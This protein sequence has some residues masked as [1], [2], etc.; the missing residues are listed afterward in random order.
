MPFK[1]TGINEFP[2]RP[3]DWCSKP[4]FP[5]KKRQKF[6]KR[7]C[8]DASWAAENPRLS[9]NPDDLERALR[10][11]EDLPISSPLF[12]GVQ[13]IVYRKVQKQKRKS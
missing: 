8:R 10:F 5:T 6:C 1:Y 12:K 4:Y 7:K 2:E 13:A 9:A 3:C 11:F